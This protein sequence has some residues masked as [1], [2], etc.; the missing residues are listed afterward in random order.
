MIID[1]TNTVLGRIA[2]RAAKSALEGEEVSIINCEKSY[3]VGNKKDILKKYK[4]RMSLGSRPNKGPFTPKRPDRFL[5]KAVKGMLPHN[6]RGKR[7]LSNV[8]CYIGMPE[9]L[10][11]KKPE[12]IKE[13]SVINLK[14]PNR[15]KVENLCEHLGWQ[16]AK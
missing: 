15:I 8:K 7:A 13:A 5:R 1:A 6:N 11:D 12:I 10:K 2:T 4:H 9:E 14:T 3:I 16:K